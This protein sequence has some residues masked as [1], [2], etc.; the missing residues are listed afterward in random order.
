[1]GV[2]DVWYNGGMEKNKTNRLNRI[3]KLVILG[4]LVT[5]VL[6]GM[7]V[8]LNWAWDTYGRDYALSLASLFVATI[9]GLAVI[10]TLKLTRD[11]LELTRKTTRPFLNVDEPVSCYKYPASIGRISVNIYNKG[12][13]PAVEVSACCEVRRIRENAVD[14][15]L[16]PLEKGKEYPSN[17]F[18][19]ENR[20]YFFESELI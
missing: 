10:Y 17:L 5:G 20:Q 19:D 2:F 3:V 11:S 7:I 14:S 6:I 9:V 12:V 16:I 8:Y 4:I 18:P 13:F 1:L 15:F